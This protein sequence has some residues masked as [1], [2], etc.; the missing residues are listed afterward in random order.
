MSA[1]R[2][3]LIHL[4]DMAAGPEQRFAP[5]GTGILDFKSI[6]AA[7]EQAGAKWGVVEQDQCYDT[8]PI[9][10]MRISFENLK[11]LGAV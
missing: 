3:P 11:K 8:P 9:E 4:K 10:A 6:L 7:S 2:T 5:V 1:K